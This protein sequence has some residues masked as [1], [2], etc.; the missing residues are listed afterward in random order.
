M[1]KYFYF[2]KDSLEASKTLTNVQI[3]I[4]DSMTQSTTVAVDR[5]FTGSTK[6]DGD[7]IVEFVKWLCFVSEIELKYCPPRMYS[8]QKIV[9]ISYYN[10]SRIRLQWTRIWNILGEHFNKAGCSTNEEVAFFAID[11]LRQLAMKFLEKGEF[12]NFRFQKDFLKPFEHIMKRNSSFSIRDMV[13]QCIAQMVKSQAQNIKSG[14]KNVFGVFHL[15]ASQNNERILNFSFDIV[16]EIIRNYVEKYF[17]NIVDSFQDAIKCLSEFA[18]NL[19][20]PD[21]SIEA[22]GHI[23]VCAGFVAREPN[24]FVDQGYEDLKSVPESDLVWMKGWFPILFELSCIINRC[25]LDVRTRGLTVMFEIIKTYGET[26]RTQWWNDLFNI[27]FR[28]FDNMKLP[29]ALVE[30]I[31]QFLY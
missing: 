17:M 5:I 24:F 15:A 6:L 20:S 19:L 27:V 7:G 26:F 25:K 30:V 14:W 22:I 8:L 23:R 13:L 29:E 12:A 16:T 11:S 4:G 21:I 2:K 28:I 3:Q 31:L 18:C 10:M 9:E 1:L